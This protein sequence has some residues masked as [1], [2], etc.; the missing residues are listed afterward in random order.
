MA[1]LVLTQK[2]LRE[3]PAYGVAEAAGY[4]RL[5]KS[6]L[7]AWLL[8]QRYRAADGNPKR[9]Q[10]VI[11]IADGKARLLSFINLTEAFVLAGI[12][13]EHGIGLSKV[14]KA[15]EY[16]RRSFN[17]PRPLAEEQ[18]ATDGLDLFVEKYG[19]LIGATQEGQIQLRE[20][21]L[22]RL[23]LVRRDPKGVPEKLVLFPA[24]KSPPYGA[25]VII[26]AKLSFGRPVLEG[27]GVR[28]A[29]VAE[30]LAAGE[31]IEM[32]ARDYNAAPDA[33]QNAIR[34]ELR[35]A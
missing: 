32:L 12:R 31:S 15:I 6:T 2:D 29:I 21:I 20:V 10:P 9:F 23:K 30:R 22:G 35:A 3:L 14:R 19:A 18:F 16:L 25:D 8:G 26:D 24:P 34:F 1:Q 28:T 4:L 5:P 13:R 27:V 33:I 11:Q 17:S 7:R